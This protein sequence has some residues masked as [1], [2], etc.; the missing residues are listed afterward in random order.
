MNK[1]LKLKNKSSLYKVV[2]IIAF[3]II[4]GKVYYEL[5]WYD[6]IL[7]ISKLTFSDKKIALISK[8]TLMFVTKKSDAHQSLI[9]IMSKNGWSFVEQFGMGYIFTSDGEELLLKR[10]DFAFGFV[11]FEVY[12][13]EEFRKR[14]SDL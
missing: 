3:L 10:R 2:G 5:K 8:K 4:A 11:V 14:F 9:E 7:G 12:P 6:L 13:R 1:Q